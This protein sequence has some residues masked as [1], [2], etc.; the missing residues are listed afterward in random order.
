MLIFK[1]LD[2]NGLSDK[3]NSIHNCSANQKHIK[4][5]LE[6]YT[7]NLISIFEY[8]NNTFTE[9]YSN[10]LFLEYNHEIELCVNPTCHI[11][12]TSSYYYTTVYLYEIENN[13]QI[14]N[15][16]LQIWEYGYFTFGEECPALE[17]KQSIEY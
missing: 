11:I 9:V 7:H 12:R 8:K 13:N 10:M 6:E 14:F 1:I 3:F 2:S 15:S 17:L 4:F 5:E 16:T